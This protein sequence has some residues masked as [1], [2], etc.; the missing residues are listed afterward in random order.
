MSIS[1]LVVAELSEPNTNAYY[2]VGYAIATNRK[3]IAR[4][5]DDSRYTTAHQES[6][7]K[8]DNSVILPWIDNVLQVMMV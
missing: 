3:T 5:G 4:D 8:Q 2:E 7:V 6:A 1:I